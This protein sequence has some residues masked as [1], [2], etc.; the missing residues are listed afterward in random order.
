MK[1]WPQLPGACTAQQS[2]SSSLDS[3]LHSP[4]LTKSLTSCFLFIQRI[5]MTLT[6]HKSSQFARSLATC[7]SLL[8]LICR[9][10]PP[11]FSQLIQPYL[12]PVSQM[13]FPKINSSLVLSSPPQRDARTKW[14]LNHRPS[15]RAVKWPEDSNQ[16]HRS[17]SSLLC[18][19]VEP[20]FG[21][22]SCI[23][24]RLLRISGTCPTQEAC[25]TQG[26]V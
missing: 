25:D 6:N 11:R 26:K 18:L 15:P 21:T 17:L 24:L 20:H 10:S 4:P 8:F 9:V 5:I 23:V 14:P 13:N 3:D 22:W 16:L 12:I 2:N 7:L 19:E 1:D